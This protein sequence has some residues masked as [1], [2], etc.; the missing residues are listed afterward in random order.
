MEAL[1]RRR[2]LGDLNLKETYELPTVQ[3]NTSSTARSA[4]TRRQV[5]KEDRAEREH[6]DARGESFSS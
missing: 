1:Q 6:V 2:P 3:E 4:R 5:F